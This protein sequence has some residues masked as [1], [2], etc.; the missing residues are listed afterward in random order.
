VRIN[1]T[2]WLDSPALG[3]GYSGQAVTYGGGLMLSGRVPLIGFLF[4]PLFFTDIG[5]KVSAGAWLDV[6]DRL[7]DLRQERASDLDGF[8][9]TFLIGFSIGGSF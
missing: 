6:G 1:Q 9:R 8:T 5:P 4:A 3:D 7:L 2:S